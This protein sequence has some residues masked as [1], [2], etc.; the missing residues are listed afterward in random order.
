MAITFFAVME[1]AVAKV[2]FDGKNF[3]GEIGK[4]GEAKADKDEFIFKNGKFRSTACD[5]YGFRPGA[6]RAVGGTNE[7]T[8]FEAICT[9]PTDGKM[10]WRGMVKGDQ[11]EG[12]ALW[13]KPGQAPVENWFKGTLK[14]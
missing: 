2:W 5:P 7:P 9:S 10:T 4:K 11:I 12:T 1:P 13:E 8:K 3:V 6:Y 14:K